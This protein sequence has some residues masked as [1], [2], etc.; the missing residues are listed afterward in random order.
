[1]LTFALSMFIAGKRKK[2]LLMALAGAGIL[3]FV[4]SSSLVP[5][6]ALVRF[7]GLS[8]GVE[9]DS[10]AVARE[11][12]WADAFE[13]F[14]RH[15]WI[16]A[17]AGAVSTYGAGRDQVYPHN[18][19]LEVAAEQGLVGLVILFVFLF[20]TFRRLILTLLRSERGGTEGASLL[21][22]LFAGLLY[23]ILGAMVSGD[24]NSGRDI[25]LLAGATLAIAESYQWESRVL[26]KEAEFG[27]K[28]PR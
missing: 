9:A 2:T 5:A 28:A 18:M 16:G 22:T 1:L 24:L 6:Q 8:Q 14:V 3:A 25:W 4:F 12:V 11:L 23:V 17:G 27:D 26:A 21:L 20:A 7:Q 13:L 15:P 19:V 10:S